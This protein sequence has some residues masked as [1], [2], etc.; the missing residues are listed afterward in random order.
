MPRWLF[1]SPPRTIAPLAEDDDLSDLAA[2]HAAAFP[3][4]WTED[5]MASLAGQP[6]VTI[7][8]ARRASLFGTRRPVGFCMYRAAADEAELLTIAVHP[9]HRGGGLGRALGE[10]ML[11]RLYADRVRRVFLEVGPDNASALALYRRL[12]FLKVAER[13]AYY[14]RPDSAPSAALVMRLEIAAA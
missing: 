6:G 11:R 1:P 14:R 7:L 8:V 12:G 5:E 4:G 10:E 9:R 2:I 3:I 13:P